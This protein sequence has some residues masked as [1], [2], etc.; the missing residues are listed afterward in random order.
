MRWAP[1]LLMWSSFHCLSS[2]P[3]GTATPGCSRS[4]STNPSSDIDMYRMTSRMPYLSPWSCSRQVDGRRTTSEPS[5]G[6]PVVQVCDAGCV[7]HACQFE[8]DAVRVEQ[9]SS[10]AE[11]DG[12][13]VDL[14]FVE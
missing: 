1:A 14:Q 8:F 3:S 4:L 6:H 5:E 11:Y 13:Q 2:A 10:V 12:D 7:E 9:S